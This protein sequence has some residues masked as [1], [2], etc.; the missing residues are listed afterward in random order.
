M[1]RMEDARAALTDILPR[2]KRRLDDIPERLWRARYLTN[3]PANARVVV[4]AKAW[5]GD[6]AVRALDA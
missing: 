2:L 6:E 4:L 1:G 5:L 3:V